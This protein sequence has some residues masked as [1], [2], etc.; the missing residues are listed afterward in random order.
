MPTLSHSPS[1]TAPSAHSA[2]SVRGRGAEDISQNVVRGV[3][4][5]MGDISEPALNGGQM[6]EL[7]LQKVQNL[8]PLP[9]TV[10]DIIA[11]RN[12]GEPDTIALQKII[13][14][15]PMITANLLKISNSVMFGNSRQIRTLSDVIKV[16]GFRMVINVAMCS[17]VGEHL[18]PD[19]SPYGIDTETFTKTSSLQATIIEKW[20]E[21]KMSKIQ[22]DLQFAAFL[23]EVGAIVISKVAI[24]KNLVDAFKQ[25]LAEHSDQEDA[26]ESVFGLSAA[27]VTSLMFSQWK[28]NQSIVDYIEGSDYSADAGDSA[29]VGSRAL[30]VAKILAPVGKAPFSPESVERAREYAMASGFG[31]APFEKML[32]RM[33]EKLEA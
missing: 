27:S 15:D 12:S 10:I 2:P 24:E 3:G 11:L 30:K 14:K 1:G 21:P 19:M 17:G 31:E 33:A 9:K 32:E 13:Q 23:Q 20:P 28:F 6:K 25:A 7:V 18:K 5:A 29:F 22:G 4:A 26:E 8:P 16:L